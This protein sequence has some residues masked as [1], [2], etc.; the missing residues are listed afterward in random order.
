MA[1]SYTS[2]EMADMHLM[3]GLAEGK[4]NLARELYLEH[5]PNRHLPDKKT[6]QRID[7]RLR[8]NGSLLKRTYFGG[9]YKTACT[10]KVRSNNRIFVG[11][12]FIIFMSL[13]HPHSSIHTF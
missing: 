7:E 11:I 6:F 8:D 9:G 4:C 5:F 10:L 2:A 13:F 1:H 3:Y 12:V